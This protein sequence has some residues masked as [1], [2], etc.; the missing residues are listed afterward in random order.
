MPGFE[1][2]CRLV[3]D[4][5]EK[6][7]PN[8]GVVIMQ[9]FD[10][11]VNGHSLIIKTLKYSKRT[12]FIVLEL[13]RNPLE[14]VWHIRGSGSVS[15]ITLLA[16]QNCIVMFPLLV[17]FGA[18][19]C[20]NKSYLSL[21][22]LRFLKPWKSDL[23]FAHYLE[24]NYRVQFMAKLAKVSAKDL[25]V[26]DGSGKPITTSCLSVIYVGQPPPHCSDQQR[27]PKSREETAD[28]LRK[29]NNFL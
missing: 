21:S 26:T 6:S 7:A 23:P 1:E 27:S 20:N 3:F 29:T 8:D 2:I 16:I 17:L 18:H 10:G 15:P 9:L 28:V 19:S 13:C 24:D 12:T 5:R 25:P 22:D 14:W 11:M 4:T